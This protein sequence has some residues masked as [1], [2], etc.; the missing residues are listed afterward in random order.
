MYIMLRCIAVP[1]R[2]N[3]CFCWTVCM[4]FSP[5]F[6]VF[7]ILFWGGC[8]NIHIISPSNGLPSFPRSWWLFP[9]MNH[10]R[11]SYKGPHQRDEG[12]DQCEHHGALSILSERLGDLRTTKG[13]ILAKWWF[14]VT[15][16]PIGQDEWPLE[17]L[18]SLSLL[19]LSP[20]RSAMT[21]VAKKK[22]THAMTAQSKAQPTWLSG[23]FCNNDRCE[24]W[25]QG[26]SHAKGL[27]QEPSALDSAFRTK[28]CALSLETR[29]V[30]WF[31]SANPALAPQLP[32]LTTSQTL[33]VRV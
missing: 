30:I 3:K 1:K 22:T 4:M 5:Y 33:F 21:K 32:T 12:V 8:Y 18:G 29:L 17:P 20:M 13:G 24:V 9:V 14:I 2:Q 23:C 28:N 19:C 16:K 7:N 15:R 27:S 31:R 10:F 26:W 25:R 6:Q 11:S